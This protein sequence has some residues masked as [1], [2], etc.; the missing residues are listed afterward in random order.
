MENC[1][2][3]KIV[4]GRLPSYKIMEDQYFLAFLDIFPPTFNGNITSPN[5]IIIPKKHYK[6]NIFE[7]LPEN[8]YKKIMNFTRKVAK[9][10]QKSIDPLRVCM[11]SEGLEIEHFHI[12]LYPIF[13]EFYPGYLSTIKGPKN[14]ATKASEK[15][16]KLWMKKMT[17][18]K[19]PILKYQ[20]SSIPKKF[21]AF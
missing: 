21:D 19:R 18:I 4:Q 12:K 17:T 8:V 6:S 1:I 7:D 10:V 13:K 2:F 16:L 5:I 20:Q 3:C 9:K 15:D 11:V 14:K